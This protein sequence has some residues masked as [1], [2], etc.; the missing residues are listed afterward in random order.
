MIFSYV[1]WVIVLIV[2]KFGESVGL[3]KLATYAVAIVPGI[4]GAM[5]YIL[6]KLWQDWVYSHF[7]FKIHPFSAFL[8][9]YIVY[10][11]LGCIVFPFALLLLVMKLMGKL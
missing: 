11:A 4:C 9:R 3:P 6:V 10:P 8:Y 5:G 2:F 7:M 1:V